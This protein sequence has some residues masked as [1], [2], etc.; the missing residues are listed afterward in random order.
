M[1]KITKIC[2]LQITS[3]E[4]YEY[5]KYSS[6]INR[7]YCELHNY[8]YLELNAINTVEYYPSWSKIFYAKSILESNEYTHVFVL[9][10]DAVVINNNKKIE[11]VINKM[12]NSIAFSENGL[13]GGELINSGSFIANKDSISILE[14]CIKRSITDMQD[15]RFNFPWEQKVLTV[16]YLEGVEMD[17]FTMNEINSDWEYD[18]ESNDDQF[19]YHFMARSVDEKVDVV[20]TLFEKH[21]LIYN[22]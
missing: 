20:K 7:K 14:N 5:S 10:S 13:N 15:Q 2:F 8:D 9:D 6:V 11:D 19:I 21:K 17:I 16:M 12:N 18:I 3:P 4:I 1:D 22:I